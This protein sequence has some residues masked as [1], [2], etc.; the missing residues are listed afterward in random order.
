MKGQ[1]RTLRGPLFEDES[2]FEG[3]LEDPRWAS[4]RSTNRVSIAV[5]RASISFPGRTLCLGT[6]RL[7]TEAS[8]QAAH[9]MTEPRASSKNFARWGPLRFPFPSAVLSKAESDARS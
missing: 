3:E 2:E 4:N 9:S 8:R 6:R 5:I 1:P 7:A